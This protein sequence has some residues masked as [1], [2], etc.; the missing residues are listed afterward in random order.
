[1]TPLEDLGDDLDMDMDLDDLDVP[2]VTELAD[3]AADAAGAAADIDLPDPF[4]AEA[5]V[6]SGTEDLLEGVDATVARAAEDY[7]DIAAAEGL[8][9]DA[10]DLGAESAASIGDTVM[11]AGPEPLA[12]ME[13]GEQVLGA[14][15][16]IANKVTDSQRDMLEEEA[17]HD[18]Q[19]RSDRLELEADEAV[20]EAADEVHAS[21]VERGVE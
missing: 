21:R 15:D 12:R 5:P 13:G 6:D 4:G 20:E 3:P 16:E 8:P 10:P 19:E 18:A 17:T 7:A 11:N 1:M 2:E 14:S 9:A